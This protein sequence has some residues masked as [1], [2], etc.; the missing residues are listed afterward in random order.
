MTIQDDID[1][2][3]RRIAKAEADRDT[4]RAAGVQERYLAAYVMVEALDFQ[5]AQ[6]RRELRALR[7][8]VTGP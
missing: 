4:W 6:K 5:L 7:D 1:V 2:L 3:N 8:A